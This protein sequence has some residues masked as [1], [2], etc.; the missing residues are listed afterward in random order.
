MATV[1]HNGS[2]AMEGHDSPGGG[3]VRCS[4]KGNIWTIYAEYGDGQW[5]ELGTVPAR[6]SDE[7]ITSVETI[8]D[9]YRNG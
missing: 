9:R 5:E 4:R 3:L 2:W 1:L 6:F 8:M 7:D